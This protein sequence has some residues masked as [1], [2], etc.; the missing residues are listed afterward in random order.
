MRFHES[1]T[2]IA[3]NP[4]GK[5]MGADCKSAPAEYQQNTS[6]IPAEYQQFLEKVADAEVGLKVVSICAWSPVLG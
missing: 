5:K 6:R 4:N 2:S 1:K 3:N